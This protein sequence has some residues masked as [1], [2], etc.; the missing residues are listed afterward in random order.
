MEERL[1]RN[2]KA[3]LTQVL[4]LREGENFLVVTDEA[5]TSVGMAF[6]T[7]AESLGARPAWY[8]LDEK[9]RPLDEI[10]EDLME[11]VPDVDIA[12]TCFT[13]RVEET[14]F[15]IALLR[16]LAKVARRIGH[17]PGIT[18]EMLRE[19]PMDVDYEAM[20]I[21]AHDVIRRFEGAVRVRLTSP[22][23]T[24]LVLGIAG[25]PFSTDTVVADGGWGNLPCGEVWCAPIEESGEGVLVCDGSIGDLGAVPSPVTMTLSRGKVASIACSDPAYR[26]QVVAALSIDDTANVV[27]E[28]GI[29]LNP[30]ARVTGNLLEDEKAFRTVHVAFGNNED[31]GGGR[32]RSRTHRDFLVLKPTMEVDFDDGR[33][34]RMIVGGEVVPRPVTR[35]ASEPHRFH[36]VLVAID[37]SEASIEA[38]RC[39]D[40]IARR[41]DA[42]LTVCHVLVRPPTVSPLFPHYV[43]MPD[44][45]W[46][47]Q[48][49]IDAAERLDDLV[50]EH[51]PRSAEAYSVLVPWGDPATTLVELGEQRGAD[52]IVLANRGTSALSRWMLGSVASSVAANARCP[53]LLVR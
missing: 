39:A 15:R 43:A 48:Q 7:A 41:D 16:A 36:N 12:F 37:Y 10:P 14:P 46:S 28:L 38:L 3:A 2:A 26:E 52:L 13:G 45:D 20:A 31:M 25:R 19:G 50:R 35:D 42:T 9:D 22:G 24:D 49:E 30:G 8:V 18:A 1:I 11:L 27:G 34:E 32:N 29:G 40:A 51:T 21:A 17:G 44:Q 6:R 5:T 23:G 47:R 53:V 4:E 33:T